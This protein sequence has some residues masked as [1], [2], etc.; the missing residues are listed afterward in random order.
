MSDTGSLSFKFKFILQ[1]EALLLAICFKHLLQADFW[2]LVTGT[3]YSLH[4]K[5]HLISKGDE[6]PDSFAPLKTPAV[7]WV[8]LLFNQ[9]L[10]ERALQLIGF[11]PMP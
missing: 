2:L 7:F 4:P 1:I 9:D 10:A 11:K 5:F 6:C 8:S 3:L